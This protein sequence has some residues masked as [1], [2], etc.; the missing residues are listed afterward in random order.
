MSAQG[1]DSR[2]DTWEHIETV[3]GWLHR[4]VLDLLR[5]GQLHDASKLHSPEREAR[6]RLTPRLAATI[7]GSP[8]YEGLRGELGPALDHHYRANRHHPEYHVNGIKDMSLFDL[9]EMV[10]DW[11]AAGERHDDG[12]DLHRSIEVNQGRFGYSDE[13]KSILHATAIALKNL[14]A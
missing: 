4:C 9:L 6:D 12:G 8:E 1:Y 7:Y 3:R 13:L 5:R 11:K 14:R 2:P 10:C